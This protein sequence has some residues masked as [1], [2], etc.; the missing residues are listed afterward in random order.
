M[1]DR[2]TQKLPA[3]DADNPGFLKASYIEA[4]VKLDLDGDGCVRAAE[5]RK[6]IAKVRQEADRLAN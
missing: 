6:S 1:V 4:F 2:G 5:Y 3:T